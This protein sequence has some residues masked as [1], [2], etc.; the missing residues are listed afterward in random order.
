MDV[1]P[2]AIVQARMSSTRLPGKSLLPI[3]SRTL[4]TSVTDSI[5]LSGTASDIIVA[6]SDHPSDDILVDYCL[7]HNIKVVRGPL[8]DVFTRF[9]LVLNR[10]PC[11]SFFRVC[12]DSPFIHPSIYQLLL[13][14]SM[15]L[16]G[17][18]YYSSNLLSTLPVGMQVELVKASSF[19]SVNTSDLTPEQLEHVTPI[20]YQNSSFKISSLY[21]HTSFN[22]IR[23]TVDTQ[24]DLDLSRSLTTFLDYPA[25][26]S[27]IL[28]IYNK[29]PEFFDS[30]Q[31]ITQVHVPIR[32]CTVTQ[33]PFVLSS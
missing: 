25:S 23:L 22:H 19:L 7:A 30:N 20:F 24:A 5:A 4:L 2:I 16:P 3:G 9:R 14:E 1:N 18:D 15:N 26:L 21:S 32:N 17:Y 31:H 33:I 10:Y 27:S 13:N 8:H 12:A 29:Y 11:S 6:T 28:S